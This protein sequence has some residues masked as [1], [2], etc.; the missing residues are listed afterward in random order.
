LD[1]E[2]QAD[3]PDTQLEWKFQSFILHGSVS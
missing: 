2:N 3:E 1:Q